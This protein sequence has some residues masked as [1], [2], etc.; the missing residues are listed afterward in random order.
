MEEEMKKIVFMSL[1]IVSLFI[2]AQVN[3]FACSCPTVGTMYP[4]T[5]IGSDSLIAGQVRNAKVVF[6]GE[7]VGINKIPKTRMLLV[8]I[9]VKESW[10][11]VLPKEITITTELGGCGYQFQVGTEYLVFAND[12][13]DG[14]LSTGECLRNKLLYKATEE[15]QVLGEGNKP[16]K[17][18]SKSLKNAPF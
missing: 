11:E 9:E 13:D 4:T 14:N 18:K 16:Q 5:G 17:N 2:F 8:K 12:S 15:L 3:A 10:K 1:S 6:S 7:V